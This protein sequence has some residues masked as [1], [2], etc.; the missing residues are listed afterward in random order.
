MPWLR[1][2]Y[3]AGPGHQSTAIIYTWRDEVPKNEQD[4]LESLAEQ[5]SWLRHSSQWRGEYEVVDGLPADI[6]EEEVQR[7]LRRTAELLEYVDR[8]RKTPII[9][10]EE[11]KYNVEVM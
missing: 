6:R 4:F 7:A 3:H 5:H 1:V 10:R 8:L 2:E 9:D 11:K